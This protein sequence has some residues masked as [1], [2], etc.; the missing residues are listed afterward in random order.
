MG[1]EFCVIWFQIAQ[2]IWVAVCGAL[3][4]KGAP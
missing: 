4:G 1:L 2:E 3:R